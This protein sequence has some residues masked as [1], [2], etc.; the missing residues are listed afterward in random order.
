[1][2]LAE[3]QAIERECERLMHLYCHYVDHDEAAKVADLFTE[4]GEW[5]SDNINAEMVGRDEIRQGFQ[6]RQDNAGRMSRHV[7][8][9]AL[10]DVIN[11]IEAVGTVYL[12]LYYYDGEAGRAT[13]PTDCLQK[14]G[15]YRDRFVKTDQGWRFSRREV[16]ANF[17]RSSD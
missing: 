11:E 5:R 9:N 10:I 2:D 17:L 16:I 4:D 7:C 3:R 13:S 15:E 8:S 14:L 12:S 6:R 1:M